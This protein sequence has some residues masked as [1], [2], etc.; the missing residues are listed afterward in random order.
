MTDIISERYEITTELRLKYCVTKIPDIEN[1][2]RSLQ[3][4]NKITLAL[5]KDMSKNYKCGT[6]EVSLDVSNLTK[7]S[8]QEDFVYK[9]VFGSKKKYDEVVKYLGGLPVATKIVLAII[10]VGI[11]HFI[12]TWNTDKP[13]TNIEIGDGNVFHFSNN[14]I[15]IV[16]KNIPDLVAISKAENNAA[17]EIGDNKVTS[18]MI[19]RIPD[20]YEEQQEIKTVSLDDADIN[21][22]TISYDENDRWYGIVE[23]EKFVKKPARIEFLNAEEADYIKKK[24]NYSETVFS[25]DIDVELKLNKKN[26]RYEPRLII[27]KSLNIDE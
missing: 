19:E 2:V 13:L 26:K 27:I 11:Y 18:E 10:G 17:I 25:A 20:S 3:A 23:D 22:R 14:T 21:I 9:I 4:L 5:S 24:I 6:I 8:F 12:S 16:R 15:E 7:G 1:V